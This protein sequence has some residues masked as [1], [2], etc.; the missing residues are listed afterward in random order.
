MLTPTQI[1]S[2]VGTY[3]L[4][5]N[6]SGCWCN[7]N[8]LTTIT[9]VSL[10][11]QESRQPKR[12]H[13]NCNR[14]QLLPADWFPDLRQPIGGQNLPIRPIFIRTVDNEATKLGTLLKE[15]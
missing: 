3:G 15:N 13:R 8:T 10:F 7:Y 4:N 12:I 1:P 6:F 11:E 5:A 2:R 9:G 14:I